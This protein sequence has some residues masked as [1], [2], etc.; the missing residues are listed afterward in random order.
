MD[1][2]EFH[3]HLFPGT[4][5]LITQFALNQ[6]HPTLSPKMVGE[7]AAIV[8]R[9]GVE[10]ILRQLGIPFERRSMSFAIGGLEEIQA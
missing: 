9:V 8:A 4:F 1:G 6:P 2:P 10:N 3:E 7:R 5:S